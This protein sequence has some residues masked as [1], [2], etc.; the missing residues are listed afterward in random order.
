MY[1]VLCVEPFGYILVINVHIILKKKYFI[2]ILSQEQ[3][4]FDSYNTYELATKVHVQIEKLEQGIGLQVGLVFILIY[5][6]LLNRKPQMDLSQSIQKYPMS[7]IQGKIEFYRVNFIYPSDPEQR[8]ILNNINLTFEPGKKIAL[9][10][11]S[12]C[13]KTTTINLIER[14]YDITGSII[15]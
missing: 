12:E 2:L 6:N 14:L 3:G 15:N 11:E 10:G 5:F 13:G 9:V 4:W 7:Q 1:A 8:L